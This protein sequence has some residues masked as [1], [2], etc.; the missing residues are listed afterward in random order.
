MRKTLLSLIFISLTGLAH[1]SEPVTE[2]AKEQLLDKARAIESHSHHGRIG[3]LQQAEGCI[4]AAKTHQA[5]RQCEQKE[6]QA[7]EQLREELRPQHQALRDE[8]RQFR[9]TRQ[10]ERQPVKP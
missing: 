3:I 6:K 7:R 9:E 2:P 1:A 4:Q 8:I 10:T 5:Y